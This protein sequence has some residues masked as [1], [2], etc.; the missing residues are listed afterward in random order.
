M[1]WRNLRTRT[2][3]VPNSSS[4]GY[5]GWSSRGSGLCI[6]RN[7]VYPCMFKLCKTVYH[8]SLFR[9]SV[10]APFFDIVWKQKTQLSLYTSNTI[11]LIRR[12]WVT[13]NYREANLGLNLSSFN[14]CW[15][16]AMAISVRRYN[17]PSLRFLEDV[18]SSLGRPPGFV[19][20][21]F[22]YWKFQPNYWV[23]CLLLRYAQALK[24]YEHIWCLLCQMVKHMTW[25]RFWT[26][27]CNQYWSQNLIT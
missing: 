4:T 22:D 9:R 20:A 7:P 11:S 2:F 8:L 21:I 12:A 14:I 24:S 5:I 19:G 1:W 27:D 10:L 16:S 6:F 23:C 25:T 17:L 26:S 3:V 13:L 15:I 18:Q